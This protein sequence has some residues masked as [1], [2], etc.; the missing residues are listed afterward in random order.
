MGKVKGPG[1]KRKGA[2]WEKDW[3]LV[4]KGKEPGGKRKVN[5]WEK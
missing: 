1:R 3:D 4:E 5:R 2:W